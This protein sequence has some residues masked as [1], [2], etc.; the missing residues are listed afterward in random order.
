M[1]K[2]YA[3]A[4]SKKSAREEYNM[5][6]TRKIASHGMVLLEN[7]GLLPLRGVKT[8]AAFGS[9]VRHTIKGGT[10]SGDVNSRVVINVEHGLE[11][12]GLVVTNQSWLDRYDVIVEQT[13]KSERKHRADIFATGGRMA[14]I[15]Y[16][17]SQTDIMPMVPRIKEEDLEQK[18]DAAI[19]VVSRNSG[20]GADRHPVPG[21]YVLSETEKQNIRALA[22]AYGSIAVI[23]NVGGVI[24]TK[25]FRE[26]P[27]VDALLLMSQPGNISGLALADVLLGK[28]TPSGHLTDTWAENYFDYP[29]ANSFSY[30][31]GDTEDEYY[32]EGIYV[33][34]RYFDTFNVTP[35]YPFGYGLSYTDFSVPDAALRVTGNDV[36]VRASICNTGDTYFGREAIQVYYSAPKGS[37]PKPYQEL[38]GFAKTR[39]IAPGE[40]E[41]VRISFKISDMASYCEECASWVLEPGKYYI[42]VGTN[43]RNTH[44]AAVIEIPERKVVSVLKNHVVCDTKF[45]QTEPNC[46]PYSYEG[47]AEEMA[48]APVFT[49]DLSAI[50]TETVQYSEAPAEMK[51]DK[52]WTITLEDVIDGKADLTELVAQLTVEEL[53]DLCVGSARENTGESNPTIGSQS[54]TVPGAAGDTTSGLIESRKIP[55]MVFADGPAGLRLQKHFVTDGKGNVIGGSSEDIL[56]GFAGAGVPSKSERPAD[57]V[58]YYQYCTAVPIATM[59]A[60]TWDMQ[61]VEAAGDIAGGEMEEFNVSLWLAPGMNIHRNPLCGRNFEYYSEDPLLAGRCAAADTKGVQQHPGRGTCIKHYAMNNSEDNRQAYNVH[62]SERAAREIYLRAFEIAVREAQPLSVMSSYNLVNGTHAANSYDLLTAVLRDEWGFKGIVMTDWG[63]TGDIY[64]GD[65]DD[66]RK[67]QPSDAA[68]CIKAGNDLTMP[69]NKFDYQQILRSVGA[70]EGTVYCPITKAELQLCAYRILKVIMECEIAKQ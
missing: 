70:K 34:Y 55:N 33:G 66:G 58:D 1:P 11:E 37:I 63:T 67:Y 61:K 59:L 3:S 15:R 12:A 9:G 25:F 42:R 7:K 6:L 4:T 69:G 24:D 31:D 20:E 43:S 62:V 46:A 26:T 47:E 39:D 57:A 44:I 29:S 18:A 17:F 28:E 51:T 23:L 56:G 40:A 5:F 38:V 50:E 30:M 52:K 68:A 13:M 27:G 8:I 48:A 36:L 53:A 45:R 22:D 32:Y 19:Y 10:G 64:G 14:L 41:T 35:A 21:D 65:A 54:I 16:L 49:A 2:I 60:Q